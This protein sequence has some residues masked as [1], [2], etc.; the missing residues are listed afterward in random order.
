[1]GFDP[2]QYIPNKDNS[3][4]TRNSKILHLGNTRNNGL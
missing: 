2:R 4:S 1:M 3:E